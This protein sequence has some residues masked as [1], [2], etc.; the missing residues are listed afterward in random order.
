VANSFPPSFC[1]RFRLDALTVWGLRMAIARQILCIMNAAN[2][3]RVIAPGFAIRS[4]FR[5]F[6]LGLDNLVNAKP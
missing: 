6:W 5:S 2:V 3:E 1:E 4:E